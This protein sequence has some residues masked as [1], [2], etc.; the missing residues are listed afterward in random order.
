MKIN[1]WR[2]YTL[3]I[4]HRAGQQDR[5]DSSQFS[6]HN[7]FPLQPFQIPKQVVKNV[8]HG[9]ETQISNSVTATTH[10]KYSLIII[11]FMIMLCNL[12]SF[13]KIH[14]SVLKRKEFPVDYFEKIY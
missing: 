9:Q 2:Y 1:P 5:I 8:F 14:C 13:E 12:F 3:S 11:F 6:M 4:T 7:S 10:V